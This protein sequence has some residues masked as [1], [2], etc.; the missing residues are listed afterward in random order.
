MKPVSKDAIISQIPLFN[1]LKTSEVEILKDMME[2]K[3]APRYSVIFHQDEKTNCLFILAKG[4]V[5]IGSVNDEGKEVIKQILHPEMIFG[6]LSIVSDEGQKNFAVSLNKSVEYFTISVDDF[7]RLIRMNH[8]LC[9]MFIT[10]IGNRLRHTESRLESLIFKDA[11]SRIIDFLRENAL[12]RGMQIGF[13]TLFKHSL[14]QQ[15]IA[16]ITGTSR[17]T[18]TSVLNELRKQNLIYFNRKSILIR[19]LANLS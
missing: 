6:E 18:V 13:E 12:S 1:V 3:V 8:Q 17:Q 10:M 4:S 14:T 7:K 15:D 5:K 16:N 19:D 2:Y 11:R 9:F